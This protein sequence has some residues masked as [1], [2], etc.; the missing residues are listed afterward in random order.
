MTLS[1]Q[2]SYLY[3]LTGSH[4]S[5]F[6]MISSVFDHCVSSAWVVL[7]LLQ[8]SSHEAPKG[9]D[10][11]PTRRYFHQRLPIC[12]CQSRVR[13]P[14]CGS[15]PLYNKRLLYFDDCWLFTEPTGTWQWSASRVW[16]TFSTKRSGVQQVS[17]FPLPV[18]PTCRSRVEHE[19]ME[20]LSSENTERDVLLLMWRS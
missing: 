1:R 3:Q 13:T 15:V 14:S 11:D 20:M 4:N 12:A 16:R 7:R 17:S 10:L 18:S 9:E 8:R 6:P 5:S 2:P 19:I